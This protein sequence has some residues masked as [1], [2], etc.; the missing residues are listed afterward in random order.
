MVSFFSNYVLPYKM[1]WREHLGKHGCKTR[2]CSL[3]HLRC[4]PNGPRW[5]F[6]SA[7]IEGPKKSDLATGHAQT[8]PRVPTH[9]SPKFG[10]GMHP[11]RQVA[12]YSC[13]IMRPPRGCLG[14]TKG[15]FVF[16]TPVL[17]HTFRL[18]RHIN[19]TYRLDSCTSFLSRAATPVSSPQPP[20]TQSIHCYFEPSLF[21]HHR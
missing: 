1:A 6:W 12:V 2:A 17:A 10:P 14:A 7:W 4:D 13:V 8:D 15:T 20:T 16:C 3:G 21:R 9:C 5:S 18:L 11:C 19:A